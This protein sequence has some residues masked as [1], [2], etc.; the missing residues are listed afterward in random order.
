[1]LRSAQAR[2][3]LHKPSIASVTLQIGLYYNTLFSI[4]FAIVVGVLAIQKV[5]V[6]EFDTRLQKYLLISICIIWAVA[7]PLRLYCGFRGN[8]GE[9]VIMEHIQFNFK[10]LIS[11]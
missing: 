2:K 3:V 10:Y 7:E 5:T 4:I 9:K 1:M 6:Y 11:Q 8:L